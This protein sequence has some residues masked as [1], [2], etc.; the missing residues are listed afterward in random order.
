[1]GVFISEKYEEIESLNHCL[2]LCPRVSL[3]WNKVWNWL[4]IDQLR[5]GSLEEIL[6]VQNRFSD[7]KKKAL[8]N[9]CYLVLSILV[10][11]RMESQ[12][13]CGRVKCKS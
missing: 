12:G 11:K 13:V 1:M 2:V 6:E 5:V 3:V 10:V 9:S 4:G 8:S 7:S